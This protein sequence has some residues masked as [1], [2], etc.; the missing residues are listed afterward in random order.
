[1]TSTVMR[2]W[3]AALAEAE[4]PTAVLA[5]AALKIFSAI[6]SAPSVEAAVLAAS[7]VLAEA[8]VDAVG[9]AAARI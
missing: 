7:A 9:Q 1:M 2:A 8:A 5:E 6:F 4:A 3:K